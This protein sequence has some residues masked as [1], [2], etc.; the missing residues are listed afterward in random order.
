MKQYANK[1]PQICFSLCQCTLLHLILI[2]N[3]QCKVVLLRPLHTN[4]CNDLNITIDKLTLL[5]YVNLHI[6]SFPHIL[7]KLI[8]VHQRVANTANKKHHDIF[9]SVLITCQPT[10]FMKIIYFQ[11]YF[12][13]AVH[14]PKSAD[15]F[16]NPAKNSIWQ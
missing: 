4:T 9:T 15:G 10:V 8:Y 11:Q 16:V 2:L 13:N 7:F 1:T 6:S 3:I 5:K 12:V 14:M